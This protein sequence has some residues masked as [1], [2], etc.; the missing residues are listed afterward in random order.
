MKNKK[1]LSIV[2]DFAQILLTAVLAVSIIFTFMFKISAVSGESM[3]NTLHTGDSVL[4][5]CINKG[6]KYGDV[7]VISAT[8][9]L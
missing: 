8:E 7:V 4:I 5:N 9:R 1:T 3:A 6:F 2:Y